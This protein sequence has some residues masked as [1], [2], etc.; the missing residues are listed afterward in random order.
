MKDQQKTTP[1][2]EER[3]ETVRQ[4]IIGFLRK[5]KLSVGQLSTMVGK[6]EKEIAAELTQLQKSVHLVIE[7]AECIR[8]GF[9][10]ADRRRPKKPGK[11]PKCKNT[12]IKEP[13]FSIM[14]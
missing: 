14:S 9:V 5:E 6:P 11:C 4:H 3:R 2:P 1:I 12:R 8:C 13:L 7:P 10:F